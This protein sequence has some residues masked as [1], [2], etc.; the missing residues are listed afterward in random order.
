MDE[1]PSEYELRRLENI[2]QNQELLKSLELDTIGATF[3]KAAESTPSKAR[4]PR[5]KREKKS[6]DEPRV[7]LRTSS[8]LAGIPANLDDDAGGKRKAE[9]WSYEKVA[10]AEKA[11][12]QRVAGD[13]SFEIKRGLFA[14]KSWDTET[15][16]KEDVD[17]T[18]DGGLKEV[19]KKMMGLK[20]WEKF[21]PNGLSR[22]S[23]VP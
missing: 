18:A 3:R 9:G 20:L 10:E 17:K 11:K 19:R 16:T 2:R 8:R 12:R 4:A 6:K 5:T 15:F 21:E 22:P 13:L 7:P 23:G 14:G 1:E